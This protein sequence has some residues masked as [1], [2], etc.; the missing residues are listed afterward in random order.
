MRPKSHAGALPGWS[1]RCA[2]PVWRDMRLMLMALGTRLSALA[3]LCQSPESKAKD[4]IK[5]NACIVIFPSRPPFV[6]TV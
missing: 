3:I 5:L 6:T 1:G 2:K 4:P